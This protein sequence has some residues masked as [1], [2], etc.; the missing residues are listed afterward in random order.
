M[1]P[2]IET[3]TPKIAKELLGM[4]E[5]N[6]KVKSHTV[7]RYANDMVEGRWREDTGEAIKIAKSGRLLDG[8]HRLLALIKADIKMDFL[9]IRELDE[10]IFDVLDT[11]SLRTSADVFTIAGVANSNSIPSMINTF[12]LLRCGLHVTTGALRPTN[13]EILEMYNMR[14]QFWQGVFKNTQSWYTA[15]AKIIP[16]SM[17]G[18]IYACLYEIDQDK[19]FDFFEQVCVGANISNNTIGVLRQ[20]LMANKLSQR[21]L[22]RDII[23]AFIIKTWKAYESGKFIKVLK[24]DPLTESYPKIFNDKLV[25]ATP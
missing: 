22:R 2:K 16:P 7:Y 10:D 23:L 18:G 5:T 20:R 21:K 14:P 17:I 6:R 1:K 25:P 9:V 8:Q 13:T 12:A 19:A 11:G 4:S 24:F 3:I 15:F